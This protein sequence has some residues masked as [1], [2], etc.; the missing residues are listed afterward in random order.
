MI[1]D[2]KEKDRSGGIFDLDQKMNT[3]ENKDSPLRSLRSLRDLFSRAK[4]A[5]NAKKNPELRC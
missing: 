5:K 1:N 3:Q 2:A 4:N